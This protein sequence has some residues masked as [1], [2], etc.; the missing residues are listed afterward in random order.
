MPPA[1]D[2]V[3][4]K[5]PLSGRPFG[6]V[7]ILVNKTLCLPIK[8]ITCKE[9]HIILQIN[10]LMLCNV[11]MPA[12]S[13]A[14]DLDVYCDVLAS[15]I[16]DVDDCNY[17]DLIVAGDLN[18]SFDKPDAFSRQVLNFCHTLSITPTY[19]LMGEANSYTFRN[20][21]GLGFSCIDH[22]LTSNNITPKI[23]SLFTLDSGVNFSDHVPLCLICELN[24]THNYDI[25]IASAYS[26]HIDKD[27]FLK[28]RWDKA[29]LVEY[30]NLTY[31]LLESIRLPNQF[32]HLNVDSINIIQ[33][34]NI[35][36]QVIQALHNAANLLI[37]KS[38]SSYY[39]VWWDEELQ[40]A[41]QKSI[42]A[43][44][45]W[46]TSGKPRN[47]ALRDCMTKARLEYSF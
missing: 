30:Y 20:S 18:C 40:N 42:A 16:N 12:R 35:Y 34:E 31:M 27:Q 38:S 17:D 13:S 28:L 2:A 10:G 29:D 8:L 22:F 32:W 39:K 46:V 23:S 14:N 1:M 33:V 24:I 21:S 19:K 47:G 7:A 44:K 4:S 36:N 11:Y 25:N 37:P 3:L 41:K 26:H 9:R 45:N 5:G 43:H 15:V 6:G